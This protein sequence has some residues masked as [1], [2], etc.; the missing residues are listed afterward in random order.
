VYLYV[1]DISFPYEKN[2]TQS[3]FEK[4]AKGNSEMAYCLI[5]RKL[6]FL[7]SAFVTISRILST[8]LSKARQDNLEFRELQVPQEPR[9][10]RALWLPV[11]VRDPLDDG[12]SVPGYMIT[13]KMTGTVDKYM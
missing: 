7:I 6:N 3:R 5:R 13:Q 9:E 10:S 2:W 1:T 8:V 12:N 4:E 11:V